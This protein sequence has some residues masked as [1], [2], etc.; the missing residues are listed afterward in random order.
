MPTARA[1]AFERPADAL[2]ALASFGPPWVVKADGLAL[3]PGILR[4]V[5]DVSSLAELALPRRVVIAGGVSGDGKAL[6]FDQLKAKFQ[7]PT[8]TAGLL[9]VQPQFEVLESTDADAVVRALK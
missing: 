8:R 9:K 4:H 2:A 1:E 5:G 6:P 7:I 3:A